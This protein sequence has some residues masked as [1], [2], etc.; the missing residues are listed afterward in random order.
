MTKPHLRAELEPKLGK[1]RAI[2]PVGGGCIANA[3]R[4]VTTEGSYFLKY[5]PPEVARTF[6]AEAAG[7]KALRAA[8][9]PLRVPEVV[10]L[11][12]DLLVLEWIEQG[13]RPA[14]FDETFGRALAHLHRC[15][16]RAYGFEMDNFIGR[17]PQLNDWHETWPAFFRDCRLAPQV[18]MARRAG[19]WQSKWNAWLD[20]LYIRLD[21]LLPA[22]PV[23]SVLHGDLWGGNYLVASTGTAAI[24]DPACYYGDRETDLAMTELFG[25]FG[26]RF[27]VGYREAWALEK[28]YDDRREIYNLYHLINHLNLFGGSY[29]GS[30]ARILQRFGRA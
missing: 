23:A 10:L 5:G 27:Y 3:S 15:A 4:I 18:K 9:A 21:A 17:S 19:L 6:A 1:I 13:P 30:V 25:G 7:L 2:E 8:G 28:G 29:A 14:S 20:A 11:E 24:F 16:G 22:S 26:A 12:E